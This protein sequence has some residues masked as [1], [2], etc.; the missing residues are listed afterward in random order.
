MLKN[1]KKQWMFLCSLLFVCI[2]VL[3]APQAGTVKAEEES[4]EQP[5]YIGAVLPG[6]QWEIWCAG[7]ETD[8]DQLIFVEPTGI[9]S[10][11][12][13]LAALQ[14]ADEDGYG[15]Y[16]IYV[17]DTMTGEL[18]IPEGLN[19]VGVTCWTHWSEEGGMKITGVY[20]GSDVVLEGFIGC[21]EEIHITCEEGK[22]VG[23]MN[24]DING[25]ISG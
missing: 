25:V 17:E 7:E 14:E 15:Y 2:S 3:L 20:A 5:K 1:F 12:D 24:A 16:W 11:E 4:E 23:M 19:G 9:E 10:F 22:S 18:V 21:G 6:E 8:P 13:M